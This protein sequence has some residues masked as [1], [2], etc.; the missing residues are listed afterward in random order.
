MKKGIIALVVA[1]VVVG[2]VV[3]VVMMNK[4]DKSSSSAMGNMSTSSSSESTSTAV[5]TNAV[6]IQNFAY[7]PDN[8]TVKKGTTVTWTNKDNT[9]HSVDSDNGKFE[10]KTLHNGDTFTFTFNSTGTFK[11]HCDFHSSMHGTVTVTE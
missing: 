8:I 2:G 7:S 6:D 9:S 11:Y 10:S 4:K 5:A 1:I 3:A